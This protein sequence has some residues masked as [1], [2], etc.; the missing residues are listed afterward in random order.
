LIFSAIAG[1]DERDPITSRAPATVKLEQPIRALAISTA[2][3]EGNAHPEVAGAVLAAAKAIGVKLVEVEPP[4]FDMLGAHC[5]TVMGPEASAQHA[6]WM[7]E[8][9]RDYSSA[10]R[11]RLEGGFAVPAARYL[12]VLRLR[13][14][15]LERFVNETLSQADAYLVPTIAVP[16][17]T[18]E[19]TGPKGGAEMPRLLGEVTR[20]TRWV[21]YLGVPALS[22]PCGFDSRGLPMGM[23]LVGRPFAEGSLLAAGHAYQRATDWHR[24]IPEPQ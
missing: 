17:P 7:R 23:Q 24:R 19:A 11:A 6:Q 9:P 3:I 15:W 21:N 16:I 5:L 1:H 14:L 12:E 10:V 4:P 22:V 8:R 13:T 18:R 2:W 20:L